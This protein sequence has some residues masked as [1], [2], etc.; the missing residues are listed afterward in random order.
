MPAL[1]G[2]RY[3]LMVKLMMRNVTPMKTNTST[4]SRIRCARC[5]AARW[6]YVD[7]GACRMFCI[8]S[9]R[10][11]T[12]S[13]VPL[14]R[15]TSRTNITRV[16]AVPASFADAHKVLIVCRNAVD[17]GQRPDHHLGFAD[18]VLAWHRAKRA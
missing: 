16:V 5:C 17:R 1:G 15:P 2:I 10:R 6:L 7:G 4:T 18:D 3:A 11:F 9:L 13:P 8:S 14:L 12:L